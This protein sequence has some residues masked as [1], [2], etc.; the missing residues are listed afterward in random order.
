M[1][2][3]KFQ[4][5]LILLGAGG[6]AKV[7]LSLVRALDL[8]VLGVCAP[9]LVN[10]GANFWRDIRVLGTGDDLTE[11]NPD[12]VALVNAV[13][14]RVGDTNSRQRIFETLKAK[15]YYFPALVHPAA[16]VDPD[17]HLQEG[18]QIMAGAVVQADA[19][20]GNNV[21]INTRASV[22]HDCVIEDHVHIAPGAVLCGNVYVGKRA[23]VASG[24]TLIPGTKVGNDAVVGAGA[25]IVRDVAPGQLVLPALIRRTEF[26]LETYCG[27]EK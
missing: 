17:A 12:E 2:L 16:C 5:P 14:R 7:L 6:H 11:F 20:I 22:D 13:G 8:P 10:Q 27:D 19:R 3:N 15:G 9:E 1:I 18:T 25:S 4:R 24:A 26:S 21:I 23:F